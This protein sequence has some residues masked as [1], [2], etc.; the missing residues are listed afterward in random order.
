MLEFDH[1]KTQLDGIAQFDSNVFRDVDIKDL[2]KLLGSLKIQQN[3]IK[4]FYSPLM[5]EIIDFVNSQIDILEVEAAGLKKDMGILR[6][7][8]QTTIKNCQKDINSF[9]KSAGIQYEVNIN[10]DDDGE[11]FAFLHYLKDDEK[12]IVDKIRNHLSWGERNAFALVL[13]MFH[14]AGQNPDLIVL[15]DP[16]SS[17]DSN[18]KYAIIHRLFAKVKNEITRSFYR[19]TVLMLTHDFEP[20]IDFVVVGKLPEE[21]E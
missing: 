7:L 20:I 12:V 9:L 11:T 18:K 3:I 6:T 2:D 10:M 15:D 13:F 4:F 17:F 16:I 1:I 19:Q 21:F 8:M 5:K 14:A